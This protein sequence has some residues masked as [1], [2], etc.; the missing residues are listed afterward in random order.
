VELGEPKLELVN[1]KREGRPVLSSAVF[2]RAASILFD[3]SHSILYTQEGFF[4]RFFFF[5]DLFRLSRHVRLF[6]WSE[7]LVWTD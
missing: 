1:S 7:D 3:P 4:I 5:V 6:A 2:L